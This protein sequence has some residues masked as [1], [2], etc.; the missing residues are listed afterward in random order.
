[1]KGMEGAN[2]EEVVKGVVRGAEH[3]L[4]SNKTG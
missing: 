2:Q 1:M 3:L 4:N